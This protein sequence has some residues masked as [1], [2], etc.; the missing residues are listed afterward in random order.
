MLRFCDTVA[1]KT[2]SYAIKCLNDGDNFE[3]YMFYRRNIV[4]ILSGAVRKAH[5]TASPMWFEGIRYIYFACLSRLSNDRG[6][7]TRHAG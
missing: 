4:R 1:V 6:S 5:C 2:C 7:S 3:L